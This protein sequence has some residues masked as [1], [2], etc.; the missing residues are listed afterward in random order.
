VEGEGVGTMSISAD[1]DEPSREWV[2]VVVVV[3][4]VIS[5]PKGGACSQNQSAVVA[6]NDSGEAKSAKGFDV[7]MDV[8][9]S[10]CCSFSAPRDYDNALVSKRP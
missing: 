2:V 3:V 4:V 10:S 8:A 7:N 6:W 1:N 5:L 9:C